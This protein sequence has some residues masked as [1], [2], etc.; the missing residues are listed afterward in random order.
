MSLALTIDRFTRHP[1]LRSALSEPRR[2][3]V[4]TL[5]MRWLSWWTHVSVPPVSTAWLRGHDIDS[6]KHEGDL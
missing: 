1:L 2:R 6:T 4:A 3:L 5:S